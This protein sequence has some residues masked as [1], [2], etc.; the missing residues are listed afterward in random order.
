MFRDPKSINSHVYVPWDKVVTEPSSLSKIFCKCSWYFGLCRMIIRPPWD[1]SSHIY[2]KT[3][4]S[5][6][7]KLALPFMLLISLWCGFFFG[8]YAF[9]QIWM[10]QPLK[11]M[12]YLNG[13]VLRQFVSACFGEC[14]VSCMHVARLVYSG[15]TLNLATLNTEL[16]GV[17]V[18][19]QYAPVPTEGCYQ[20][21]SIRNKTKE[22]YPRLKRVLLPFMTKIT[23]EVAK[24][25]VF[26]KQ[27][28]EIAQ[29][30][31]PSFEIM[32]SAFRLAVVKR[33]ER[34]GETTLKKSLQLARSRRG[35]INGVDEDDDLAQDVYHLQDRQASSLWGLA[36]RLAFA[37]AKRGK[38]NWKRARNKVI[39][40]N[41][42]KKK[43]FWFQA[44]SL[45]FTGAEPRD[46]K[47]I[48]VV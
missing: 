9:V 25:M 27:A 38:T 19:K 6:Y 7:S 20:Q 15:N 21:G 41:R 29:S 23:K 42:R 22:K 32:E 39:L 26:M 17:F 8:T 37:R 46:K 34:V 48:K 11:K 18:R 40:P 47:I 28:L 36:K 2:H 35:I 14:L 16:S 4:Q 1:V 5:L 33:S 13:V 31:L 24:K 10:L 12:L 45:V 44:K 30:K 43:S 3:S